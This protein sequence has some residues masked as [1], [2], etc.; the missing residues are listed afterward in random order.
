MALI[1]QSYTPP[2]AYVTETF[3]PS[4]TTLNPAARLAVLIGEGQ[5]SFTKSDVQMFRGSSA[6]SDNQVVGENISAQVDGTTRSF[7]LAHYP[8]VAG[9]GTGTVTNDP[10]KVKLVANGVPVV[11]LT[12]NGA[13]GQ[14]TTQTI[15]P[16]GQNAVASYF[17][18]NKDTQILNEDLTFEVPAFATLAVAPLTFSLSIPGELGNNVKLTLT[19][20]ASGSGV[21]DLLAVTG[22]GTDA[23]SIELR[24]ADNTVRSSQDLAN[25]IQAGIQT[26]DGGLITY[27][28]TPTT[29]ALS[30]MIQTAFAGGAGQSTNTVFKVKNV[31]IVDGT[32]G[33]VVTTD[34]TKVQAKVDGNVVAVTA[35]DGA[36]GL[37]TLAQGVKVPSTLELTYFTNT[38]QNTADLLPAQSVASIVRAGFGPG[39]TDF[40]QGVDYVLNGNS[41]S[42]GATANTAA[43]KSTAGFT[44]FDATVIETTLVDEKVYLRPVKGA[45]SGRNSVFTLWDVPVDGS[46]N[47]RPTDNPGLISV[48]VGANPVAALAAGAVRVARLSGASAQVTLYNPPAQGNNVYATYYRSTLNDH[49]FT[50]AVKTAGAPG[51]GTYTITDELN[52]IAPVASNGTDHVTDANFADTGIVFPNNFSDLT[53][54]LGGADETVTLTFQDDSLTKITTPAVQASLTV[55]NAIR[56]QATTPGVGGNSVTM[57]LVGGGSGAS[58]A[59]AVTVSGDNISVELLKADGTTVRTNQEVADLFNVQGSPVN[60]TDGGQITCTTVAGANNLGSQAAPLAQTAFTGGS[61]AI[62]TAYANRFLVTTSR[63]SQQAQQDGLGLT[64]GATTPNGTNTTL[65]AVGYLG[66]TYIDATTAVKF[67]VVDPSTALSYGFT[68]LPSPQYVYAPGDTLTF[69]ISRENG[70][71]TGAKPTIAIPG[72][73]TQVVTTLGM[74]VADTAV[75]STFNRAGKSPAVGEVY[76]ATFTT[77]KTAADMALQVFSTDK[78]AYAAYGQPSLQNRLSLGIQKFLENAGNIQFACIQVPMQEGLGLASDQSFIDAINSLA[79]A[80]PGSG[81]KAGVIVPLSTSST[82]QQALSTFLI[83]QAAPLNKGEATAFIGFDQFTSATAIQATVLSIKNQ[84]VVAS[85]VNYAGVKIQGATDVAATEWPVTGEFVAAALAGLSLS[86]AND[87]ATDLTGQNVVGFTRSLISYDDP[88]KNLLATAGVTVLDDNDGALEVR[89]YLSTDRSNVLTSKPYVTTTADFIAQAFRQSLKQFKGRKMTSDLPSSI[90]AVLN[91]KLKSW[92]S[93]NSS[94]I[95]SGYGQLKVTPDDVDPTTINIAVP[96]RPMFSALYFPVNLT[97]DLSS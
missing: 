94:A 71:V 38:Y 9:D 41:I 3:S 27:T 76:Y 35:V 52:Q 80:L 67:T 16:Q 22:Q 1:N 18:K 37:V 2:G 24:K 82:V 74:N 33:G 21:S 59:T 55:A 46:G 48:Y 72:L 70:H 50:L 26:S 36:N 66:Q 45:V 13:T 56:F 90:Q 20:A 86:P 93:N 65:G 61:A 83:K 25:L 62:S 43:G 53:A 4:T 97:V 73:K 54:A 15:I 60:T 57:T 85:S 10:T 39:R 58:D 51:Q 19:E 7:Q 64:G 92:K 77:A 44:P 88:T 40:V 42:W 81:R 84:R 95:L 79:M 75:I 17:F 69:T 5:E 23:I 31:P 87:V 29:S 89:D 34:P 63:T 49:Q 96:V 78:A 91:A 12:L 8:V 6:T 30:A 14:I 28:G 47:G 68:Q 32:N 11:V